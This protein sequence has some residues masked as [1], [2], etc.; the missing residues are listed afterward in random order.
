M[1]GVVGAVVLLFLIGLIV[2]LYIRRK[3]AHDYN[4]QRFESGFDT[5]ELPEPQ[6]LHEL[7][8]PKSQELPGQSIA[9]E[10]PASIRS[11]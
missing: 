2:L 11:R 7:P 10:L 5:K 9:W 1:G 6:Q 4:H 3:K 8:G